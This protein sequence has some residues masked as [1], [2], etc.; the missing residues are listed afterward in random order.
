MLEIAAFGGRTTA[1]VL[2]TRVSRKKS[3]TGSGRAQKSLERVGQCPPLVVSGRIRLRIGP[4]SRPGVLSGNSLDAVT[5]LVVLS[6]E[7]V[8]FA[9]LIRRN[10]I[11]Q[12]ASS[13]VRIMQIFLKNGNA[14]TRRPEYGYCVSPTSLSPVSWPCGT[15]QFENRI[16]ANLP[17]PLRDGLLFRTYNDVPAYPRLR[18]WPSIATCDPL[19]SVPANCQFAECHT[20]M[21]VG[22]AIPTFRNRSFTSHGRIKGARGNSDT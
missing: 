18:S 10:G 6:L 11:S 22:I 2:C 12:F 16:D 3:L 19:V 9:E 8:S 7:Q 21:P 1:Y 15:I 14:V 20:V 5:R 17:H 13:R 4:S